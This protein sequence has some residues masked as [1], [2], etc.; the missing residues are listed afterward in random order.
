MEISFPQLE[1]M[2]L[3]QVNAEW[4]EKQLRAVHEKLDALTAAVAVL[5][6]AP[7]VESA[8]AEP[9]KPAPLSKA[10]RT[11]RQV[12]TPK[13]NGEDQ[14]SEEDLRARVAFEAKRIGR[15]FGI[16]AVRAV[17]KKTTGENILQVDDVP[18]SHLPVL[19]TELQAM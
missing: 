7:V 17:I 11:P 6:S 10:K 1:E 19:L 5:S 15:T 9:S 4:L 2:I 16:G 18:A 13:A 12:E 3:G 14:E 8:A